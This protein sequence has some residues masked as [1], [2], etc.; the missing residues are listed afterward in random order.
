MGITIAN[1]AQPL[2]SLIIDPN[3]FQISLEGCIGDQTKQISSSIGKDKSKALVCVLNSSGSYKCYS[4]DINQ[5]TF[6]ENEI[7]EMSCKIDNYVVYTFYFPDTNE[8]I[9][10]CLDYDNNYNMKR[11]DQNFNLVQEEY[12]KQTKF[13]CLNF[14]SFSV[15]YVNKYKEY[16]LIVYGQCDNNFEDGV[17]F[18]ELSN[19]CEIGNIKNISDDWE[20]NEEDNIFTQLQL[21][22]NLFSKSSIPIN[23]INNESV[24]KE[25]SNKLNELST[26]ETNNESEKHEIKENLSEKT[27]YSHLINTQEAKLSDN[28][29]KTNIETNEPKVIDTEKT[30]KEE[31]ISYPIEEEKKSDHNNEQKDFTNSNIISSF[32][33][34]QL[35][36]SKTQELE[37]HSDNLTEKVKQLKSDGDIVKTENL[38]FSDK[39]TH[40]LNDKTNKK[41]EEVFKTETTKEEINYS[42]S[43]YIS[44]NININS[45]MPKTDISTQLKT[46]SED[47]KNLKIETDEF[48]KSDKIKKISEKCF[49]NEDFPYLLFPSQNCTNICSVEQLIT[50][51]CKIDCISD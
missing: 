43:D 18:F 40:I 49:C 2:S 28:I 48:D 16:I 22:S 35:T 4:Y 34:I 47:S 17:R 41:A 46:Y 37:F 42:K 15:V 13:N 50:Q 7:V 1:N 8:F 29:K 51:T 26:K 20:E 6:S 31:I 5:K 30:Q 33:E 45:E 32:S 36:D 39:K 27:I 14:Y 12:L 11:I 38:S 24:I 10:S 21:N 44:H 19:K 23:Y 9:T 3:T 25:E